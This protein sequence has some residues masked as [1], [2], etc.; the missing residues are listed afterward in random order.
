MSEADRTS[1]SPRRGRNASSE[2]SSRADRR[3][4]RAARSLGASSSSSSGEL[5]RTSRCSGVPRPEPRVDVVERVGERSALAPLQQRRELDQLERSARRRGRCRG[6]CRSAARRAV[7]PSARDAVEQ[8]V[9][10]LASSAMQRLGRAE[11]LLLA[12]SHCAPTASRARSRRAATGA[13]AARVGA[14]REARAR[15]AASARH[16]DVQ[17]SPEPLGRRRVVRAPGQQAA[18]RRGSEPAWSRA[19][20]RASTSVRRPDRGARAHLRP[21]RSRLLLASP[22]VGDRRDVARELARRRAPGRATARPSSPRRA[23]F[24]SR[25]DDVGRAVKSCWRRSPRRSIRPWTKRSARVVERP[26]PRRAHSSGTRRCA[27]APR[28]RAAATRSPAPAPATMSSLP[29]ARDLHAARD[30][31]RRQLDRRSRKRAHDRGGVA[32]VDEQAQPG[33]H[34][35]HLVRSKNAPAPSSEG[36]ARARRAPPRPPGRPARPTARAPRSAPARRPRARS[37]ARARPRR[38]APARARSRSARSRPRRL[39]PPR[40]SHATRHRRAAAASSTRCGQRKLCVSDHRAPGLP[41][42]ARRTAAPAANAGAPRS[43]ALRRTARAE[44]ARRRTSR[45]SQ[46]STSTGRGSAAA[47]AGSRCG[48]RT[49]RACSVAG[50][51]RGPA[52]AR[53]IRSWAADARRIRARRGVARQALAHARVGLG[54][55]QVGLEPVDAPNESR[56]QG[57]RTAAE[58]VVARARSRFD[59][60]EQHR[61][62]L[63]GAQDGVERLDP[64]RAACSSTSAAQSSGIVRTA[65]VRTWRGAEPRSAIGRAPVPRGRSARASG[66]ARAPRSARTSTRAREDLRL[67][68]A[69]PPDTSSGASLS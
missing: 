66:A 12:G 47:T 29:P 56:E 57:Q 13:R 58:V 39:A 7:A 17:R 68:G 63:G 6:R 30:V 37:A 9:T 3:A 2:G 62:A 51:G 24:G 69:R 61:E 22:D 8:L 34:V 67:A 25:V 36:H 20:T 49:H 44:L 15:P 33:E 40:A 50:V 54:V 59:A 28:G 27:R 55:D 26:Q 31:D 60:L 19:R 21:E 43:A 18:V 11:Q 42:S 46:S 4:P 1:P 48:I 38:A 65:V 10:P 35:A 5:A 32:R 16:R 14:R 41:E 52:A 64:A 45:S 23:R 53:C